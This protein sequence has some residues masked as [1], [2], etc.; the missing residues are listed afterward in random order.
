ME[1]KSDARRKVCGAE[2][3][4]KN[5]TLSGA[6][7]K[8][9]VAS[10][11]ALGIVA[12]IV[13]LVH[14]V[15]AHLIGPTASD[16]DVI[17][18]LELCAV[19]VLIGL[20]LKRGVLHAFEFIFNL[21][22]AQH[23]PKERSLARSGVETFVAIV[24]SLLIFF[25]FTK[26]VAPL[27]PITLSETFAADVLFDVNNY[28]LK[29]QGKQELE[30]RLVKRLPQL[31]IVSVAVDGHTDNTG[32]EAYNIDLSWRR[33]NEIKSY[34]AANAIPSNLIEVHGYGMSKSI[35]SNAT[36]EGRAKNRRVEIV[37]K[38]TR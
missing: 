18:A 33:A 9:I 26:Y 23:H 20:V 31:Q 10:V 22:T 5:L 27:Q 38:A 16:R 32:T 8:N 12:G 2:L 34:L 15:L 21:I 13:Y 29:A 3:H 11:A 30:S 4:W 19:I 6:P 7:V 24:V 36:P 28:V 14:P 25:A 35:A 1:L 17:L 37:V